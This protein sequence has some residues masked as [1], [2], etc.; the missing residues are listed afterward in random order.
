MSVVGRRRREETGATGSVAGRL[1]PAA[2][3]MIA[4]V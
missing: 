2:G 3:F 1:A 4:T